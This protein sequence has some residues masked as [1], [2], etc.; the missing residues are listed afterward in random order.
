L[1]RPIAAVAMICIGCALAGCGGGGGGT[2]PTPV[3]YAVQVVATVHGTSPAVTRTAGI[4][5]T[6]QP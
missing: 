4:S 3:T 2:K 5:V 1:A 6:V